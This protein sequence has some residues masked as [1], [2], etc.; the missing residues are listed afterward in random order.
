M[1]ALITLY[2]LTNKLNLSVSVSSRIKKILPFSARLNYYHAFIASHLYYAC[3]VWGG[4]T[5][6]NRSSLSTILKRCAKSIPEIDLYSSHKPLFKKL[7]WLPFDSLLSYRRCLIT[8]Q[9][10]TGLAPIYIQSMFIPVNSKRTH[11]MVSRTPACNLYV[12]KPNISLFKNSFAYDTAY[13][14]FCTDY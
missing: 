1:C 4:T 12:P 6:C 13:V 5:S 11:S 8:Y 14:F 2:F 9:G 7:N 10:I 3:T